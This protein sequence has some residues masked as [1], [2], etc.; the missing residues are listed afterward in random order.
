MPYGSAP[1][2]RAFILAKL[3]ADVGHEVTVFANELNFNEGELDADGVYL[4]KPNIRAVGVKESGKTKLELLDE[5]LQNGNYDIVLKASSIY[6]YTKAD[7]IIKLH[8]VPVVLDSVEWFAPSNWRLKRF[9]PRYYKFLY[10]WRFVFPKTD[11]I[12]AISRLIESYYRQ[13]LDNVVRIPTVTD[14]KTVEPRTEIKDDKIRFIF[15]G[16][17]DEGKDNILHFM[18]ALDRIDPVK[19]KLYF[20]IYGPRPKEINKHLGDSVKLFEKYPDNIKYHGRAP[21]QQVQETC[22]N[23]DFSVFFRQNIRSANAGFPTKL[24]ECMTFGTP[25]FTND[26]GDISLVINSGVNGFMINRYD[27]QEIYETLLKIVSMT[28]SERENMR[29][30]ARKTAESFFDYRH[31]AAEINKVLENAVK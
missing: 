19:H 8:K 14:P 3:I 15:A 30:E 1:S 10:M 11:G 16:Q 4:L 12:I 24:G 18:N 13:H 9:D 5:L 29:A 6:G 26:T 17:L 22:K 21:Q 20:D 25:A 27:E 7:K 2:F 23:A 28:E 31:Y